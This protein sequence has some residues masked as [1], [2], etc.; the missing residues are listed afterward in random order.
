MRRRSGIEPVIGHLKHDGHLE[1][2]HLAGP[3]GDAINAILS[4]AGHNMRLLVRWLRVIWL[5]FIAAMLNPK[6]KPELV[7]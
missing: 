2:N 7:R 1:R 5:Y 3:E 6:H 4:A